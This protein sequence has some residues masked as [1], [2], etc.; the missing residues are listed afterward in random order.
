MS[1][2]E[3]KNNPGLCLVKGQQPGL[4][5]RTR[6]WNQ[7]LS[8]SLSTTKTSP[9]CQMLVI[10]PVFYLSSCILPRDPQEWLRSYNVLNRTIS[11]ELVSDFISLYT[12]MSRDPIHPHSMPG[13]DTQC[14]LA[15][16]YQWRRCFGSLNCFQSRLAVTANTHIFLWSNIHLNFINTG[17]D[18]IYLNLKNCCILS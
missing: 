14:L 1:G 4:S 11:C 12:N 7:F 15:L 17:Q 9:P 13:R 6:A 2:K 16:L 18:G 8:L 10:H 5:S 3:A